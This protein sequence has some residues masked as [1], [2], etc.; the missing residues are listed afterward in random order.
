MEATKTVVMKPIQNGAG[1]LGDIGIAYGDAEYATTK[2]VLVV[3]VM[4]VMMLQ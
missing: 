4:L 1:H 3:M 2:M